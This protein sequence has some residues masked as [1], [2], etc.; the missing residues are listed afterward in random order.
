MKSVSFLLLAEFMQK[1][2]R[3][4]KLENRSSLEVL[5]CR[6]PSKLNFVETTIFYLLDFFS[7]LWLKSQCCLSWMAVVTV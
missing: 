1:F 6:K 5:S 7:R 4:I 3:L 2:F